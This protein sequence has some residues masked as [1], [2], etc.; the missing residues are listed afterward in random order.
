MHVTLRLA[1]CLSILGA[2]PGCHREAAPFAESRV[3]AEAHAATDVRAPAP[4]ATTAARPRFALV[5][6]S[7]E[8]L[9]LPLRPPADWIYERSGLDAAVAQPSAQSL[10]ERWERLRAGFYHC[11]EATYDDSADA[12]P[13]FRVALERAGLRPL[14]SMGS[15]A[16]ETED[17]MAYA[18]ASSVHVC[19]RVRDAE[20][21]ALVRTALAALPLLA[22]AAGLSEALH[23]APTRL[24]YLR[25]ASEDSATAGFQ[26]EGEH[27]VAAMAWLRA[28]GFRDR[29]SSADETRLAADPDSATHVFAVLQQRPGAS[30]EL[31]IDADRQWPPPSP[32][33]P[34]AAATLPA[35]AGCDL[36]A[37]GETFEQ[38]E[39]RCTEG[40]RPPTRPRTQ[41]RRA[42]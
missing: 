35:D 16:V 4:P 41:R 33:A 23:S 17:L 1:G 9:A 27:L 7:R 25:F 18:M 13:A 37:D 15:V 39:H 42:P 20:R 26:V 10:S 14:P 24:A 31:Q 5:A 6:T 19:S 30:P 29:D 40:A 11:Y 36:P 2:S 12:R 28:H 3:V 34:R 22:T 21:E 38:F 32:A 8:Q